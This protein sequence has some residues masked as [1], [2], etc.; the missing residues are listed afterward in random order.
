[1][2]EPSDITAADEPRGEVK[3]TLQDD[4]YAIELRQDI[5]RGTA[6]ETGHADWRSVWSRVHEIVRSIVIEPLELAAVVLRAP[7]DLLLKLGV[8][9]EA[10]R[11]VRANV[12][13]ARQLAEVREK[14]AAE[15]LPPEPPPGAEELAKAR[16]LDL[17][18]EFR[19]RG[20]A[21]S[22][23]VEPNGDITFTA[24]GE[25]NPSVLAQLEA[26]LAAEQSAAAASIRD[27]A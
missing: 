5:G 16:L 17:I 1:M 14:K 6:D 10:P 19:A 11:E 24:V 2:S 22:L 27:P 23:S 8:G 18:K 4:R 26:M 20:I 21:V 13:Y 25:Q 9:S 12:E 3:V 7:R 15:N